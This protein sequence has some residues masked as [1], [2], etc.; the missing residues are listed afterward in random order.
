MVTKV[1]ITCIQQGLLKDWLLYTFRAHSLLIGQE[2]TH[3][4]LLHPGGYVHHNYWGWLWL[5]NSHFFRYFYFQCVCDTYL[6]NRA[7][8]AQV[9]IIYFAFWFNIYIISY[10]NFITILLYCR[11]V[12]WCLYGLSL[13]VGVIGQQFWVCQ[14]SFE[15]TRKKIYGKKAFKNT[16]TLFK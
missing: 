15:K 16:I 9:R 13:H 7:G 10:F 1:T 2:A 8:M 11:A 3:K 4:L 5:S 12:L 6:C 14:L